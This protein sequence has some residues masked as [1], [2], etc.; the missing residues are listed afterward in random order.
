MQG[1][2]SYYITYI[3][4][5]TLWALSERIP[6]IWFN[7]NIYYLPVCQILFCA[8]RGR[9]VGDDQAFLK[10]VVFLG[11]SHI[12]IKWTWGV[13]PKVCNYPPPPPPP[14]P[15]TPTRH[16]RVLLVYPAAKFDKKYYHSGLTSHNRKISQAKFLLIDFEM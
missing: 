9:G 1:D 10:W 4:F 14:H 6:S 5:V 11:H 2:L 15:F 7:I 3:C 8:P 16:K 13:F 12:I